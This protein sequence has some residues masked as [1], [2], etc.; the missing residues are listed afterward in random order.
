MSAAPDHE[1]TE[2]VAS[3]LYSVNGSEPAEYERMAIAA[4]TALAAAGRLLPTNGQDRIEEMTR[5]RD[6]A[7]AQ[8]DE[9]R[10]EA[11]RSRD[12]VEALRNHDRGPWVAV[13]EGSGTA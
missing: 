5:E 6:E 3:A 12:L 13:D 4:L 2:L 1:T 8:R 7:R 11:A 10:R 9:A